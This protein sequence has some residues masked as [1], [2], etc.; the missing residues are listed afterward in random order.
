MTT[1]SF[2][3]NPE[4][5]RIAIRT[6]HDKISEHKERERELM[7]LAESGRLSDKLREE[8]NKIGAD[9]INRQAEI[10]RLEFKLN[11]NTY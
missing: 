7:E 11:N 3:Q 9:I 4:G 1:E 2:D 6:H 8:L 10:E 5:Y